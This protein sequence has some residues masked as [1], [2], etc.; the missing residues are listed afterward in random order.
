MPVL[1][2]ENI[3]MGATERISFELL[4]KKIGHHPQGNSGRETNR[5]PGPQEKTLTTHNNTDQENQEV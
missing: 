1:M 3:L 4:C 2:F 5:R